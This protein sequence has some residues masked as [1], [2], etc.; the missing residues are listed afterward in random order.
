[1]KLIQ[2]EIPESIVILVPPV[3]INCV[4]NRRVSVQLPPVP[5]SYVMNSHS[6]T[7]LSPQYTHSHTLTHIYVHKQDAEHSCA[8]ENLTNSVSSDTVSTT[9]LRYK[10]SK[11]DHFI[12]SLRATAGDDELYS[13]SDEYAAKMTW[14]TSIDNRRRKLNNRKRTMLSHAMTVAVLDP[15]NLP[16]V[17]ASSSSHEVPEESVGL[18]QIQLSNWNIT[19]ISRSNVE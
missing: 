2:Y 17:D 15:A 7:L 18:L 9:S 4:V 10:L 19:M 5:I 16:A 13:H 6:H 11:D 3:S 12:P 14:Y 1:M 8:Q